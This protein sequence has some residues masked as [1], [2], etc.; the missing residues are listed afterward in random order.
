M[1]GPRV[2]QTHVSEAVEAVR[3]RKRPA[4]ES[5]SA[6]QQSICPGPSNRR[7][8]DA[9]AATLDLHDLDWD[10]DDM[11]AYRRAVDQASQSLCAD[12]SVYE[13]SSSDVALGDVLNEALNMEAAAGAEAPPDTEPPLPTRGKVN[14]P[15]LMTPMQGR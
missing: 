8:R 2:C 15:I 9:V 1:Q 11:D 14:V 10:Q 4:A 13:Q 7:C 12:P 5:L 6:L 3:S